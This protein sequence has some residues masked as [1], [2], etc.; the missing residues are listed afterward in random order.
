MTARV[1]D[2]RAAHLGPADVGALTPAPRGFWRVVCRRWCPD[3]RTTLCDVLH[4]TRGVV[5]RCTSGEPAHAARLCNALNRLDGNDA[6][7]YDESTGRE[8]GT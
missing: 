2:D 3:L 6:P 7:T 8:I 5:V 1:R 4:T